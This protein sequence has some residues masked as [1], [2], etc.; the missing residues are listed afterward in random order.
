MGIRKFYH[1]SKLW[2][3]N[4]TGRKD[5]YEDEIILDCGTEDCAQSVIRFYNLTKG[6]HTNLKPLTANFE[7]FEDGFKIFET[8]KDVFEK[9]AEMNRQ[10]PQPQDVI[11]MLKRLGFQEGTNDD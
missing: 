9:L 4:L 5:G 2:P 6:K 11:E 7:C 3:G 8:C 10:N 1:S